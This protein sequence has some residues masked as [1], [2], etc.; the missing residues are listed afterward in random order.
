MLVNTSSNQYGAE[1]FLFTPMSCA[2][3]SPTILELATRPFGKLSLAEQNFIQG[4]EN[5]E[6]TDCA[7]LSGEDRI[8]RARLFSWLCTNPDASAQAT[9]RGLSI[10]GADIEGDVDLAWAK[11]C[12]PIRAIKCAFNG[13]IILDRSHLVFLSLSGSSVKGLKADTA[14]FETDVFLGNGFKAEGVVNLT[15]VSVGGTLDCDVA[16][17]SPKTKRLL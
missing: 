17:L 4:T 13:T 14:R 12:F 8:I 11:I 15:S 1:Y 9:Y 7:N 5:G 6:P 2:T 16:S 3:T 10:A